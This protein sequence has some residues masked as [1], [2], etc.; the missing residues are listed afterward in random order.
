MYA[1]VSTAPANDHHR[2]ATADPQQEVGVTVV[3]PVHER[4]ELLARTLAGLAAQVGAT[5][6]VVVADD[7][8]TEDV[9][10]VVDGVA[11]RL[12]VRLLRQDRS[13]YGAARAR[14]LAAGEARHP[15]LLF[16][17]AD[18]IPVPDL[19]ARHAWWHRRAANVAVVGPRRDV[20]STDLDPAAIAERATDL[21]GF[22][23]VEAGQR[24]VA[25]DDW[26][27]LVYR[28]TRRLTLGDQGFRAATTANLSVP[29]WLFERVGGFDERFSGWGGEDTEL[30]WRLW[31]EGCFMVPEE[32]ALALHQTQ[33]D[34]VDRSSH[35]TRTVPLVA[36][37]VPN[38]FYRPAPTPLAVVPTV[39][40]VVHVEDH[41]QLAAVEAALAEADPADVELVV[42]G[43]E[44]AVGHL[45]DAARDNPRRTVVAGD[46]LEAGAR[47]AVEA[48]RGAVLALVDA[49]VRRPAPRIVQALRAMDDAVARTAVGRVSYVI[50]E[51]RYLRLDDLD[52]V[53]Q[54][55]SIT[56]LPLLAVVRRREFAKHLHATDSVRDAWAGVLAAGRPG[57]SITDPLRIPADGPI[58]GPGLPGPGDVLAAGP[59]EVARAAV[60]QLRARRAGTP[61][62]A[63]AGPADDRVPVAYVGLTGQYNLG[64]DAVR[65]AVERLLP[66]ANVAPDVEGAR[67]L[68]VGGGT[69]LNGRRYYQ[70]RMLRQESPAIERTLF[71]TGVRDP[72]YNGVTEPMEEWFSF[73]DH[74]IHA[75][76][77][78]PQSIVHLEAMGFEGEV[79]IIG[80]PAFSLRPSDKV[81]RSEGRVIVCPVWTSGNLH[82]GDDRAVFDQLATTIRRLRSAG[83]EVLMLSAF[84]HDDRHLIELMRAAGAPDM[85]YVAGYE[86]VDDTM[87]LLAGADLVIGERLHAA[88]LAAS[89]GTAFVP[90]QYRP[91]VLDFARSVGQE[92]AVVRTDEIGRLDEVVDT[93]MA[94]R[95]ARVAVV[96]EHVEDYRGRQL[97]AAEELRAAM[98]GD[99][100]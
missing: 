94:E 62:T 11:D 42:H 18:C 25:P 71:G 5:F 21:V 100:A 12:D 36:D 69:L 58:A 8:S 14:N 90:L 13:G 56:G 20:D 60:R 19:V 68:L 88:I 85:P 49:R 98:L 53:D 52:R 95:E 35:R 9:A 89:A 7:G 33:L 67:L 16:L 43:P 70:T 37:R 82:G 26:R 93:V 50:G 40:W 86:S 61:T 79:E 96:A 2:V 78:G 47:A 29:R 48:A 17:D 3:V 23:G 28:R 41:E 4:T 24:L 74:A 34:T 32:R 45:V 65:L 22:A 99:E 27:A 81:E 51:D 64:D 75:S 83:H 46:D 91:K 97:A 31:N 39:S 63:E 54:A 92:D 87:D 59:R 1:P 80:D 10:G 30:A 38:D 15:V 77:R 73:I 66:W 72:A 55:L 84:P 57:L 6:E 44:A 76:V